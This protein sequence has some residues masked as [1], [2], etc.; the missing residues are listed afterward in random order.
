MHDVVGRQCLREC[1]IA[2]LSRWGNG[3]VGSLTILMGD[4]GKLPIC[5]ALENVESKSEIMGEG[6]SDLYNYNII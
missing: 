4:K 5:L 6:K 2:G 3:A 1:W